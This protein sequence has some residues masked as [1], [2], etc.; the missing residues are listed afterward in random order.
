MLK[1]PFYLLQNH[2]KTPQ[3]TPEELFVT[4][5]S[6]VLT[7]K[8]MVGIVKKNMIWLPEHAQGVS[9]LYAESLQNY[10]PDTFWVCF[11]AIL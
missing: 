8:H 3:E 6:A 9:K 5:T 11:V 2:P 7:F 10:H 4:E 1:K